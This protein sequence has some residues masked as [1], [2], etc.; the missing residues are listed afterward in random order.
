MLSKL[1]ATAAQPP[2]SGVVWLAMSTSWNP[3]Q[4]AGAGAK[5]AVPF[6]HAM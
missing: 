2:T 3:E 1:I 6:C 5:P 4:C